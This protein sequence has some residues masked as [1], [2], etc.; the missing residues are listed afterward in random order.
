MKQILVFGG[1]GFVGNPLVQRL[2]D[3][4]YRT[5]IFDNLSNPS[6]NYKRGAEDMIGDITDYAGV[7]DAID[8]IKPDIV[9]NLAA[10]HYIPHCIQNPEKTKLINVDGTEN[11]LRAMASK[12][13]AARFVFASSAAVYRPSQ[14][15]HAEDS[16]ISPIDAYGESKKTAEGL[17]RQYSI[18]NN[19]RYTIVRLFNVYGCGD[20]TPH[21]I[22]HIIDQIRS[23]GAIELGNIDTKRDY[24]YIQDVVNVFVKIVAK[25]E[26]LSNDTYNIGSE[27]AYSAST[28]VN[29]LG[30]ILNK[31]FRI[32]SK[33]GLLRFNDRPL[34][35]SR[36]SHAQQGL[37]WKAEFSLDSGLSDLIK[38]EGLN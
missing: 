17:I 16:E 8:Q 7:E 26:S 2:K 37:L 5:T 32:V 9:F 12:V 19:L 20:N 33:E 27:T 14:E 13:P 23:G 28:L 29:K 11:I 34:L 35:L 30:H 18:K 25:T 3:L 1:A 36:C 21:L 22:P 24:I 38:K 6:K 15:A 4:G 31:R 10:L